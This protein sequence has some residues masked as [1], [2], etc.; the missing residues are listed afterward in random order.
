MVHPILRDWSPLPEHPDVRGVEFRV[1]LRSPG[2]ALA[3]LRFQPEA[4]IHEHSAEFSVDVVCIEGSGFV[5]VGTRQEPLVAGQTVHWPAGVNHRLW[6]GKQA[7]LTLMV[8]H[9]R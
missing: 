9:P 1:L 8:E 5:Q 6:T 2:L 4:T 3:Q 7:M